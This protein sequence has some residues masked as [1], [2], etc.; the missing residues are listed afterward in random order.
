ME[1]FIKVTYRSTNNVYTANQFLQEI[2]KHDLFAADFETASRYPAAHRAAMEHELER[3]NLPKRT[4]IDLAAKLASNALSHPFHVQLTHCSIA[5]S[6]SEAFV[7]I[8]DNPAITKRLLTFLVTTSIRQIW[9]NASFDFK[10]IQYHMNKLPLNFED[11]Q[12][13]AKTI[14]NHVNITKA[15]TGL[16]D[17]AGHR[18]G[19]WAISKDNFDVENMYEE[20]VLH[21]VAIDACATFWLWHSINKHAK[22][23]N[24][25]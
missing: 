23:Q 19:N 14:L 25:I 6:D 24:V 4:R 11:T 22:E 7:F 17:L 20:H 16:K 8:L 12:I 9:H 1:N 10:H 2:Q 3:E 15:L 18:Y 21:Y 13:Y 5:I